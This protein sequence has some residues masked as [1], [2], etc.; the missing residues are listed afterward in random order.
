MT[1]LFVSYSFVLVNRWHNH[2]NPNIKREAWTEQED[3]TLIHAHKLY[4]NKW[5]EI[6]K[7]LPGR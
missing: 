5:A 3:L 2:L 7:F 4:G 1:D 6:A